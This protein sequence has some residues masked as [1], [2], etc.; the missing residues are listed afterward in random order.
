MKKIFLSIF[1]AVLLFNC[2]SNSNNLDKLESDV[3]AVHDEIMP[4][5]GEIMSLKSKLADKLKAT[6]S[7]STNYSQV[8]AKIDSLNSLLTIA[9]DGMMDWMEQYNADTLK[10][11]SAENGANYLKAQKEKIDAVKSITLKNLADVND[12]LKK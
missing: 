5:M 4:K 3:M 6:D 7:T 12:F 11:I 1:T 9:D 2:N 10:V 8:K